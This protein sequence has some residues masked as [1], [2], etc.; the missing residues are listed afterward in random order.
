[1]VHLKYLCKFWRTLEM[2]QINCEINCILTWPA[3]CFILAGTVTNQVP[4]FA[5]TDTKIN[6]LK[7]M[8]N[9]YNN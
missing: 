3:N 5:I 6:Q 7:I 4:T 2:P 9:V 8:Q 1:M